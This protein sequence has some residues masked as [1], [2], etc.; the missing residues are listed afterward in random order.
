M[1]KTSK[2]LKA[3]T[4]RIHHPDYPYNLNPIGI[5]M[6]WGNDVC[7]MVRITKALPKREKKAVSLDMTPLDDE[8]VDD[9]I[10]SLK[11]DCKT[12]ILFLGNQMMGF[13][14]LRHEYPFARLVADFLNQR[15]FR[16]A[17]YLPR[18]HLKTTFGAVFVTQDILTDP[19]HTWMIKCGV[20]GNAAQIMSLIYYRAR[21]DAM[22]DVWGDLRGDIWSSTGLDFST[23][24]P[25]EH[26]R[27]PNVYISGSESEVT[28]QHPWGG[29]ID[30]ASGEQN[31][32]TYDQCKKVT[33]DYENKLFVIT[34]PILQALTRW[35]LADMG[36]YIIEKNI[37]LRKTKP[38]S[39]NIY[40][41]LKRPVYNEM[42]EPLFPEIYPVEWIEEKRAALAGFRFQAQ[43][44]LNPL[45]PEDQVFKEEWIKPWVFE[46]YESIK[47][48]K[49]SIYILDD[50]ASSK[51][52]SADE[53]AIMVVGVSS[54]FH[55]YVM[56]ESVK[57]Y[58]SIEHIDELF[59]L[60]A[61]WRDFK[62]GD[63]KPDWTLKRTGMEKGGLEQTLKPFLRQ[64]MEMTGDIFY[65]YPL[66]PGNSADAKKSRIVGIQPWAIQGMLHI[67]GSLK[68]CITDI[69]SYGAAKHD[70]RVD[71]IAYILQIGGVK[72]KDIP[73]VKEE[74]PRHTKWHKRNLKKCRRMLRRDRVSYLNQGA[75]A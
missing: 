62:I 14:Y 20:Y 16:M 70:D 28:G 19:E 44:M 63:F 27:Q 54:T 25:A 74:E 67:L 9:V 4:K 17:L 11:R 3:I 5:E 73:A 68:K 69:I 24:K 29:F 75:R 59:K 60:R 26:D 33:D 31:S 23:R 12:D 51:R 10:G 7:D 34:G 52:G 46:T 41:I 32:K 71:A 55:L 47:N 66:N 65:C 6:P 56:D 36:G 58:N 61:K 40:E 22:V 38:G 45:N 30:D 53:T 2:T 8:Y 64:R 39:A 49:L 37:E 72:P 35:H 57:R 18:W 50:P 1:G 21:T 15:A 13:K 48:E 43:M 42:M